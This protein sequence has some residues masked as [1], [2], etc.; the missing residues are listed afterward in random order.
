[1]N[2]YVESNFVLELTLM[3]EEFESCENILSICES[4]QW[5]LIIPAYSLAE[6]YETLIRRDKNRTQLAKSVL[7][8]INQLSRSLPYKAE[9]NTFH[10]LVSLLTKSGAEEKVRLSKVRDRLLQIAEILPLGKEIISLASTHEISQGLKP[11]DAVV[12][13]SVLQHLNATGFSKSCFLNKNSKDFAD[14][15]IKN[16][17][18][19]CGCKIL[20]KFEDGYQYIQSQI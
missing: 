12:Y 11:Q 4:G 3:Q 15:D 1:M 7:D 8:E 9:I 6:P 13:A 20:F 16:A 2:I 18:A 17:L 10:T 19:S 14:P 5:Q